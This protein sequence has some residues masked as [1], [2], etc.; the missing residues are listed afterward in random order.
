MKN[1]II[2]IAFLSLIVQISMYSQS[3]QIVQTVQFDWIGLTDLDYTL[4]KP[5]QS[6]FEIMAGA[7]GRMSTNSAGPL[8]RFTQSCFDQRKGS[9]DRLSGELQLFG[10]V[11]SGVAIHAEAKNLAVSFR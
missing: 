9:I 2:F 1:K 7:N 8:L 10:N 3:G 6:S 5:D 4:E 11:R